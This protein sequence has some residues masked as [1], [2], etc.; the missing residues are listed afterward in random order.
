MKCCG[1]GREKKGHERKRR[2]IIFKEVFFP[3]IEKVGG[4]H[5]VSTVEAKAAMSRKNIH[6]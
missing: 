2:K 1:S 3:A 5:I 4:D 6:D